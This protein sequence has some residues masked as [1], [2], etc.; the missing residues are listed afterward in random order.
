MDSSSAIAESPP[1]PPAPKTADRSALDHSLV[2]S[3]AWNAAADW[4]TQIFTWMAF[5]WVMRLLRPSDFGIA[6]LA[7]ILMPYM[8]QITGFGLPRAVVALPRL[9]DD[10]FRQMNGF[11]A[12]AGTLCLLVAVIIAKPFA[13]FFRIP[14]LAPVFLVA[15]ISIVVGGF[16]GVPN[17]LLAKEL[18]FRLLSILGIGQTLLS[19][20]LVLVLAL[21]GFGYWSLI[22]GNMIPSLCRH[23][24]VV[25][26]KPCRLA[27]P[28]LSSIR[29]PLRFGWHVSVST[30]ASYAYQRLDNLVAGRVLGQTALGFYGNAWELANVPL[31]KVASLVTTVLPSYLAL[32]QD[33]AAALRRYLYGLT[34]VVAMA[35]FP[36]CVGLGLV[37]RECVPLILGHKWD[38]MIAPLEVLS[39]YAAFRAVVALL[40]KVLTAIG[41]TRFVMWTDLLGVVLLPVAFYIGSRWGITGIA[42]GWVVA[43]PIFAVPLYRKTF[44]AIDARV[45]DYWRSLLP[46]L[47]GMLFMI[48][49]V[50]WVKRSL[51]P[52]QPL[53]ARLFL[54][55]AV[56]VFTYV[57]A[58]CLFHRERVSVVLRMAGKL[59]PGKRKRSHLA[60]TVPLEDA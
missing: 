27:W 6:A 33:D 46:S 25:V 49:S 37:A 51:P 14:E 16:V 2:R 35:A 13:A 31:E 40:P 41:N 43:Y 50:V 1:S 39:I 5:L 45:R 9:S 36:A 21:K 24:I 59:V 7:L 11:N 47:T 42:W 53:F 28:R 57:A 48:P 4:G 22:L 20:A 55:V 19:S 12:I 29:E 60:K 23:A 52:S 15:C 26:I 54:E 10:Q 34:E 8:G 18:R 17:A 44:L 38:G 3:V 32:V 58:I 30:I 56:G